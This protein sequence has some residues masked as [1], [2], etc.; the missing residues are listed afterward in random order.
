MKIENFSI[1]TEERH[2]TANSKSRHYTVHPM[3]ENK[4]TILYSC[5]RSIINVWFTFGHLEALRW[6]LA[7]YTWNL[8]S[9][10]QSSNA[11][12]IIHS[13]SIFPPFAMHEVFKNLKLV[14]SLSCKLWHTTYIR[15]HR[16]TF[17]FVEIK[18]QRKG[19]TCERICKVNKENAVFFFWNSN[20]WKGG[21]VRCRD[22]KEVPLMQLSHSEHY[23]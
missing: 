23:Q 17:F 20:G 18:K 3:R 4:I 6:H 8:I 15:V 12:D 21:F 13:L 2:K 1:N 11:S 5:I 16:A 19:F 9:S 14:I 10:F 22:A 7:S